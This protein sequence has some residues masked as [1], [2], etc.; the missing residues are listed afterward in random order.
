MHHRLQYNEQLCNP[1]SPQ[2]ANLLVR[3]SVMLPSVEPHRYRQASKP[4]NPGNKGQSDQPTEVAPSS[5]REDIRILECGSNGEYIKRQQ[6]TRVS[7]F[8]SNEVVVFLLH[9]FIPKTARQR[10]HGTPYFG[11]VDFSDGAPNCI[12][13]LLRFRLVS[14]KDC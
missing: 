13:L 14:L 2:N 5:F 9:P 7:G 1:V 6:N 4:E 12:R 3:R 8:L 11:G 10:I